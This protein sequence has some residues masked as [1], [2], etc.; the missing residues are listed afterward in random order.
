[1]DLILHLLEQLKTLTIQELFLIFLLENGSIIVLSVLVGFILDKTISSLWLKISRTELLWTISTLFLNT[2]ITMLGFLLYKYGIVVFSFDTTILSIIIDTLLLIIAMDFLMFV[3]HYLIHNIA[4]IK[5]IHELHHQYKDPTAVTLYV[6]HPI[7]VIGFG[8]LWLSLIILYKSSIIAVFVYL[9]LNI[10]MG[11]IGHLEIEVIPRSWSKNFV[12]K[13]I[14]DT[15]FHNDHHKD[16]TH[17]YGFYT[18][19]WDKLF[20]TLK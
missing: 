10:I 1:M 18:S 2:L 19:L 20:R 12:M 6:L 7:E 9:F 14:A 8:S 11:M 15:T 3:F 13:W 17:N 4:F 5:K 16:P